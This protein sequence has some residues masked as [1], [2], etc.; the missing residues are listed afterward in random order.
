MVRLEQMENNL[1]VLK[2]HTQD[3]SSE[4]K[5]VW[6]FEDVTEKYKAEELIPM[7]NGDYFE[8][9][10]FSM[11]VR[12]LTDGAQETMPYARKIE[13]KGVFL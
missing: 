11:T 13:E 6:V 10:Q 12:K 7:E 9:K 8:V 2:I 1:Y 3:E 4:M 5:R